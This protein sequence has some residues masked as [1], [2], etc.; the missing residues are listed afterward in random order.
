MNIKGNFSD[1]GLD[2]RLPSGGYQWWYF[3]FLDPETG[4]SGVF[5]FYR[6]NPFSHQ[7]IRELDGSK[8]SPEQFPALSIS[9]YKG[10]EVLFNGFEEYLAEQ[11]FFDEA[12]QVIQF[13]SGR[14]QWFSDRAVCE[15]RMALANG[16]TLDLEAVFTP[17]I[18]FSGKES[19][20]DSVHDWNLMAPSCKVDLRLK[21]DSFQKLKLEKPVWGYHDRNAGSAPM[22]DDFDD[23]YWGRF[24]GEHFCFVYYLMNKKGGETQFFGWLHHVEQE[25]IGFCE[26]RLG[27]V[28][29]SRFGLSV[30]RS[31]EIEAHGIQLRINH[32][33]PVENSPF[34][35]RFISELHQN[36][37]N[38]EPKVIGISEFIR[39]ERIY[40]RLFW[41]LVR[42]RV[43]QQDRPPHWVSRSP[44]FTKWTW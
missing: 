8:P 2:L 9:L 22:K 24:H 41:P 1:I 23:W 17:K 16:W 32:L 44:F 20:A 19:G 33:N 28:Q 34:Y 29:L 15:V 42:M 10:N 26:A 36:G 21:L 40:S 30:C 14:V 6:G 13:P 37:L 3:D 12:K 4:V 11:T 38:A 39:P 35:L 7:Y 27:A 25:E 43:H 5:I 31:F 18:T